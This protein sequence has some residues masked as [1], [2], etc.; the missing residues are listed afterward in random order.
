MTT[1]QLTM[2][3]QIVP[4]TDTLP[5]PV[6]ALPDGR[7]QCVITNDEATS[8]DACER[9]ALQLTYPALRQMLASHF[10]AVSL[11]AAQARPESGVVCEDPH[12]YRVDG[13]VGRFTFSTHSLQQETTSVYETAREVFPPLGSTERYQTEGYKELAI[14]TGVTGRSYRP[15]TEYLNRFRHQEDEGTPMRTLRDQT[16]REGARLQEALE[17]QTDQILEQHNIPC[18]GALDRL[19]QGLPVPMETTLPGETTLP[20]LALAD[21]L[22]QAQNAA[23]AGSRLE[24]NPVPYESPATTVNICIDDVGTKRQKA[25]RSAADTMAASED[26]PKTVQHT[27]AA[28][29]QRGRRYTLVGIGVVATLRGLMAFLVHNGCLGY[30]LLFFTDGQRSL[31]D[32]IR[33][34][35]AWHPAVRLI[36]DWYHLRKKC[37]NLLSLAMTGR[38]VRNAALPQVL[39]LLWYGQVD[40]AQT[41]LDKM[42]STSVKNPNA[43]QELRGYLE[44]NRSGIPCYAVRKRLGLRNSSQLGEKMNDVVVA[45]RQKHRGMSWSETGSAALASLTTLVKNGEVAHWLKDATLEFKLAA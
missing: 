30:H 23:P 12:P 37:A 7:F 28:V 40:Q 17:R 26:T 14:I 41:F 36:L 20:N 38:K 1:Y 2:A 19:P 10:S 4:T 33:R 24:T 21:A 25:V 43:V 13:E 42:E 11:T 8:I 29:E 44:R 15:A 27:V 32:A 31:Q 22:A 34:C 18:S 39:H 6:T 3:F 9:A 45:D 35:F 5:S 16:E